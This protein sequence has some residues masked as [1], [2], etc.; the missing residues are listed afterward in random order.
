MQWTCNV[1]S[2]VCVRTVIVI[3]Q[4]SVSVTNTEGSQTICMCVFRPY[5]GE[6]SSIRKMYALLS[7]PGFDPQLSNPVGIWGGDS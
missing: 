5:H 3:V 4:E 1:L 2:L 6:G 7:P